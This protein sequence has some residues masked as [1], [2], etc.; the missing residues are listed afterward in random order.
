MAK[1][2]YNGKTVALI[3]R[4]DLAK[5]HE[6]LKKKVSN[7]KDFLIFRMEQM[8]EECVKIA[9]EAGS[10]QDRTGNL[11]SSIG[12]MVMCDGKPVKFGESKVFEGTKGKGDKGAVE[13][14]AL[15]KRLQTKYPYGIVLVVCAGMNYAV[16]VE[17]L[18]H[19]DVLTSSELKLESMARDLVSQLNL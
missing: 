8:G 12:Y 16:Y 10:Y 5:L 9:R 2:S 3:S 11:R 1:V 7:M 4:N 13:G 17:A 14:K 15:L 18:Y 19:K 6:R